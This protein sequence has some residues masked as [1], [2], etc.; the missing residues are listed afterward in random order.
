[1]GDSLIYSTTESDKGLRLDVVL[2]RRG[3]YPSRNACALA[4]TAGKITKCGK[5]LK[6]NYK[7]MPGMKIACEIDTEIEAKNLSPAEIELDIRYEDD[8]ILVISKP[9]GLITHPSGPFKSE[10]LMNALIARYGIDGL[11]KCQGNEDRPGIVHRLDALT[12]GLM[13][14]AKTNRAGDELIEMIRRREVDRRYLTLVHGIIDDETGKIDAPLERHKTHRTKMV[15]GDDSAASRDAITTFSVLKRYSATNID[16]GYTLLECKL[17]TGRTHQIRVHMQ[18][19]MHPVVGDPL[20]TSYAPKAKR[21]SLGLER[22]FLHSAKLEFRHPISHE[23]LS[24]V[25]KLPIELRAT[26]ESLSARI[27]SITDM[28]DSYEEL[29]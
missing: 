5:Q 3:I 13:I 27:L 6:K 12:S 4:A 15:V 1:M 18:Y 11:C 21:S 9:A 28:I 14:C 29:I 26:L 10:T 16:N 19:I 23:E 24:F 20:Y 2:T 8:D 17:D 22:Q 25:D 7:I